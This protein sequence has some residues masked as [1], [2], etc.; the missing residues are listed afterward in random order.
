MIS[1]LPPKALYSAYEAICQ[2]ADSDLYFISLAVVIEETTA[3]RNIHVFLN[4][5]LIYL[6]WFAIHLSFDNL[7]PCHFKVAP[8]MI[9]REMLPI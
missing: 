8:L 4:P 5:S 2:T 3:I 9:S 7:T 1:H 6:L